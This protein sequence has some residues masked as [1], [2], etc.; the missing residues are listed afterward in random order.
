MTIFP[1]P[2]WA[3]FSISP[4]TLPE[5]YWNAVSAEQRI[6]MLCEDL[7]K[8]VRQVDLVVQG[9]NE[10]NDRLTIAE[11]KIEQIL[12]RLEEI[13]EELETIVG[14]L[15]TIDSQILAL[16][17]D[18]QRIDLVLE[19]HALQLTNLT[20]NLDSVM[21]NLV[22]INQAIQDLPTTIQDQID[23]YVQTTAFETII[24]NLVAADLSGKIDVIDPAV[25]GRIPL[26]D[27]D[28]QLEDSGYTPAD[29]LAGGG[30][31]IPPVVPAV[32]GNLPILKSD[33]TLED[34]GE[35]IP[36]VPDIS[37]LIPAVDPA[38]AGNVPILDVDGNLTDSGYDPAD[39][40]AG[41][42]GIPI[43]N[44]ATAG[45]LPA[46]TA[47]GELADSGYD[48]T[49][50]LARPSTGIVNGRPMVWSGAAG[51]VGTSPIG[52]SDANQGNDGGLDTGV[53]VF[54]PRRFL[55]HL[56]RTAA[57][58]STA[59]AGN[60]GLSKTITLTTPAT[61]TVGGYNFSATHFDLIVPF[62]GGAVPWQARAYATHT[63][64]SVV[65]RYVLQASGPN[66][67]TLGVDLTALS[68]TVEGV[69]L[70]EAVDEI[71]AAALSLAVPNSVVWIPE[72]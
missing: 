53:S 45:N 63:H 72:D 27:A 32:A 56:A 38:V 9:L 52:L 8:L 31:G 64:E 39:F 44:P 25:A 21:L 47:G 54:T 24:N 13:K 12:V 20:S 69:Q 17:G 10:L 14:R 7:W 1:V 59:L 29:F 5:V 37:G 33:G 66:A 55:N 58:A 34:S 30:G 16:E 50:F 41:G 36:V 23:L 40:L 43:V 61:L 46:L 4:I 2:G 26:I 6:K 62:P 68:W 42:G 28:G 60:N 15:D 67:S 22:D 65:R 11:E 70:V 35:T 18:V 49:D 57:N 48:P 71:S 19:D 3:Y 51:A